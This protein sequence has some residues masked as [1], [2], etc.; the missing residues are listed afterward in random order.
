MPKPFKL[1]I[2]RARHNANYQFIPDQTCIDMIMT[3]SQSVLRY[4]SDT[5][6]GYFDFIDSA[7]MPWVDVTLT[8]P[9]TDRY[10]QV[11]AAIQ[12]VRAANPGFDPLAGFDGILLFTLPGGEVRP[13]GFFAWD[14]GSGKSG[15]GR[16]FSAIT[17]VPST[18]VFAC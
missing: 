10:S 12:A 1:A 4:W 5:T 3:G 7:M 9:N 6:H 11:D 13:E 14:G 8:P 2:V 15:D 18:G 17:V 16:P